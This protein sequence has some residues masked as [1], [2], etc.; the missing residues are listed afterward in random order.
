MRRSQ[1]DISSVQVPYSEFLENF[2]LEQ[3][4]DVGYSNNFRNVDLSGPEPEPDIVFGTENQLFMSNTSI[5][6]QRVLNLLF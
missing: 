2:T 1:P 5:T 6:N 3:I 4:T